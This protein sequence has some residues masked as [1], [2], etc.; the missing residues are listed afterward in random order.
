MVSFNDLLTFLGDTLL[1][2]DIFLSTIEPQK[3]KIYLEKLPDGDITHIERSFLQYKCHLYFLPKYKIIIFMIISGIL[4]LPLMI[5]ILLGRI[6]YQPQVTQ[7]IKAKKAVYLGMSTDI[8]PEILFKDCDILRPVNRFVLTIK[9]L[10]LLFDIIL[11]HPL[12]PYF[13][14]KLMM[15]IAWYRANIIKHEPQSFIATSE[16]SFTSSALTLF[17]KRNGI[18]H[19]NVMHGDKFYHIRD[20]FFIFDKCYVWDDYYRDLFMSLKAGKNQFVIDKPKS[21]LFKKEGHTD[22]VADDLRATYYLQ[23]EREEE[24][25]A[26]AKQLDLLKGSY[27][28]KI[29]PHPYYSN[30]EKIKTIFQEYEIEDNYRWDI[31]DSFNNTQLVISKYSTVLYQAFLY[32]KIIVIDDTIPGYYQKLIDMGFIMTRKRHL[33]LSQLI[34]QNNLNN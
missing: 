16:Y 6:F 9:D 10:I 1:A 12:S 5:F 21:F 20:A 32:G 24:L 29:R 15:K 18:E 27:E 4:I 17:C 33:T 23:D 19:I 26:L 2:N 7:C 25:S 34:V 31:Y 30:N 8:L 22:I 13:N 14:F 28:I 11:K 3:Q